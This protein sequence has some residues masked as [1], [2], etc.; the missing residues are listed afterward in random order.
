MKAVSFLLFLMINCCCIAQSIG[1][2]NEIDRSFN[3]ILN[4]VN[5]DVTI[6][7]MF[8]TNDFKRM[9]FDVIEQV[10]T[11]KIDSLRIRLAE[12]QDQYRRSLRQDSIIQDSVLSLKNRLQRM[13]YV[14][15]LIKER[16]AEIALKK[17][18]YL[19]FGV[20]QFSTK[21]I[22][23]GVLFAGTQIG[24]SVLG[25]CLAA[26]MKDAY[27]T[28]QTEPYQSVARQKELSGRYYGRMAGTIVCF[29][30]VVASLIWN[31]CDNFR[32]ERHKENIVLSPVII[33][34][35]MGKSQVGVNLS[36]NF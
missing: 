23:K 36:V 3:T 25:G 13:D 26:S 24:L 21:Q 1:N 11:R 20:H 6:N 27:N 29:T 34:D 28:L 31:Y 15:R 17:W 12:Y 32:K 30:G 8:D 9:M 22:G 10:K 4:I 2:F 16:E 5:T 18:S 7:N 33:N 14:L 35:W 19:P